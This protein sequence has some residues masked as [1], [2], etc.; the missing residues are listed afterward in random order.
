MKKYKLSR[1]AFSTLQNVDLSELN[2]AILMNPD[3]CHVWTDNLRLLLIILNEEISSKGM[4]VDQ[5]N[6]NSYG[7]DLYELYDELID[8][9]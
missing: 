2:D 6:V 9:K 4:D 1:T 8:Q 7:K 3:E 5:Q